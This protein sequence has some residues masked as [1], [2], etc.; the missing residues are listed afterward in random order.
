MA[1]CPHC[2]GA[3]IQ[4]GGQCS[5]AVCHVYA[6]DHKNDIDISHQVVAAELGG[7]VPSVTFCA[8]CHGSHEVGTYCPEVAVT[9][10]PRAS[11]QD[12]PLTPEQRQRAD[13]DN[14]ASE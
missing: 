12:R 4:N 3:R 7:E 1:R 9:R 14:G 11:D 6:Y 8:I 10:E 2:N 13:G 5:E